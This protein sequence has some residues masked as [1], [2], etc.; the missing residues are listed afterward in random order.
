MHSTDLI[1][2]TNLIQN[3][4]VCLVENPCQN[5][6]P[7]NNTPPGLIEQKSKKKPWLQ[8]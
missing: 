6:T 2:T 1:V 4:F 3:Q 7:K 8:I 5:K